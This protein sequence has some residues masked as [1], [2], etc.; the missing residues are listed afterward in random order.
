MR[1]RPEFPP[2]LKDVSFSLKAEHKAAVVG[3]TGAGKSS[4]LQALFRFAEC[5]EGS[6]IAVAG[7][8]I[9]ELGLSSLRG[10]ISVIPQLPFIFQ[11]SIR[12]NLDPVSRFTDEQ[13]WDALRAVYLADY[14]ASFKR[15][16]LE[17]FSEGS[18]VFSAG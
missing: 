18:E 10:S 9:K 5:D 8:D 13:L 7:L 1:Y 17:Q 2:A 3:R 11:G 14:V 6:R 12:D 15:G 16:L 4:L